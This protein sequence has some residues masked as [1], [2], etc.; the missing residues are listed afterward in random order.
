MG[1]FSSFSFVSPNVF[2]DVVDVSI[3]KPAHLQCNSSIEKW[4]SFKSVDGIYVKL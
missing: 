3:N 2:V 1:L 4:F